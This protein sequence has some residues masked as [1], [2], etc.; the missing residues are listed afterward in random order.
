MHA[1]IK[2]FICDDESKHEIKI[3]GSHGYVGSE[4][5]TKNRK[6]VADILDGSTIYEIQTGS[7]R[8]LADKIKWILA[9]T[10]YNIVLV[11]PLAEKLYVSYINDDGSISDRKKSP[12]SKKISAILPEIYYLREIIASDRLK[13]VALMI[14]ADSYKKKQTVGKKRVKTRK[15]EMIPSAIGSARVF[16]SPEDY[17]EFIPDSLP[18]IFTTAMFSRATKIRGIDAYS[19]VKVLC[20]LGLIEE[21]GSIGRARAYRK[22]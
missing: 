9:N 8:P 15:Y 10:T 11:H 5:E 1:I 3:Q 17:G 16:A 6:F 22:I 12:A 14:E 18:E 2:R 19:A 7:F 4:N 13:I 20:S 21:C